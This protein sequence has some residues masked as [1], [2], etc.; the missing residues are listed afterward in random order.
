MPHRYD[1]GIQDRHGGR[2]EAHLGHVLA[3]DHHRVA[4]ALVAREQLQVLI[5]GVVQ[6]R[7]AQDALAASGVALWDLI[8]RV[9]KEDWA[10][11]LLH[12]RAISSIF[13]LDA[14]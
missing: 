7:D 3:L 8:W 14:P 5:R 13:E 1:R 6:P 12:T 9:V 2:G 10:A 4:P 11:V